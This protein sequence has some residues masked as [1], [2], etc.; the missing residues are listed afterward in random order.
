MLKLEAWMEIQELAKQGFS[1]RHIAKLTGHSR[2]TVSRLLKLDASEAQTR[3]YKPRG[4]QLDPFKDYIKQRYEEY[5]LSGVRLLAEIQPMGYTGSVDLVQRYL[6]TL[7]PLKKAVEKATLRYETPP[8]QQAQADWA[9]CGR[10]LD[11]NGE[12]I[13]IYAFVMVL[14]FSRMLYVEFTTAMKLPQLIAAHQNAFAYFGGWPTAILYDN[15]SQVRQSPTEFNPLFVDFANHYGLTIKTHRV[16]R[17]RTKGKVE[18]MVDYLKDNF[19]NARTFADLADLNAQ[20]RHWLEHTANIRIHATTN[21]RPV[22]LLAVELPTL[23]PFA[24]KTAYQLATREERKVSSESF[25]HFKGSRYSVPPEHVGQI[26]LV[27][28]RQA[29]QR[30]V[31]RAANLIIA[32]HPQATKRGESITAKAHLDALWKLSLAQNMPPP[33]HYH[34]SFSDQ[35]A[36]RP[37]SQY[38]EVAR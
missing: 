9:Y 24:S 20:A 14:S 6:K 17:P 2:A 25:V 1:Q 3:H 31:I 30:V 5:G 37:L 8:G 15:M 33:P 4:S 23:T 29:E 28:L 10:F 21:Q 32:D 26:V 22:D 13:A 11:P 38:E 35:V 12:T 19:L 34:I 16:R 27:E 7:R 18:R 36:V